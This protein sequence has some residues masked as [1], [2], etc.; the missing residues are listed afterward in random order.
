MKDLAGIAL[1]VAKGLGAAFADVRFIRRRQQHLATE[2]ERV[3]AIHD[4]E[5]VGFGVRVIADSAWGFA[6]SRV[7]TKD[8]VQKVAGQAVAIAKASASVPGKPVS[9]LPEPV[10]Q[11]K[12]VS[13][14]QV[15]PFSVA[16]DQKVGLLLEVNR[17][18]LKHEGI[19]KAFAMMF[20]RKIERFYANSEG[21][22]LESDVVTSS[23]EYQATAVGKGDSKHRSYSPPTLTEG[24]ENIDAKDL[25]ANTDRVA[26]QAIE[27]LSAK[28]CP[29]GKRDLVLDPLNLMLTIH[30]SVGHATEL[31]RALGME[32]SL[33]GRTFA[34]PDLLGKLRYGSEAVNLVADNTLPHGL[35]S[36]GFDDD[37]VEMQCWHIVKD[38]VFVGYSTNRE[39]AGEIGLPRSTGCCRADSWASIPIVRQPNL[40]LMPGAKPLSPEELIS[41][42]DEG[43]YIEGIGSFS[44]DQMRRNFQFGGDAFWEIKKGKLVG[45]LKNVTYQAI[46]TDFWGSCDAVCDQRFWVPHGVLG[47]GKGDPAQSAQM[48]HGAATARFRHINVG[49]AR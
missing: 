31:D 18:L 49:A 24:Y 46:T 43:I 40:S 11:A 7:L 16:V 12:F 37:G 1:D 30:E 38:G 42:T 26:S 47:C 44:I 20:F 27:H 9:L 28:E 6:G 17:A 15:D 41:D 21:S 23:T 8:E 2:D 22:V 36:Q 5:D 29:V 13:P 39:V 3:A 45:M 35:C 48:T 25:M 34:T 19:K 32:E 4:S 33:A 10:R 14:C